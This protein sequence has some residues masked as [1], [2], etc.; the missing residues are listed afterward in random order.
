MLMYKKTMSL[1]LL[2]YKIVFSLESFGKMLSKSSF[3]YYYNGVLKHEGFI[4]FE[5]VFS[6]AKPSIILMSLNYVHS[7]ADYC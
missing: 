1:S 2:L 7:Y 5:K 6:R 4:G 3:L